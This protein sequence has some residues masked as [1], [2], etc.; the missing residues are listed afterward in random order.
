MSQDTNFGS[1]AVAESPLTIEYSLV[2]I[3]EIRHAVSEG[4]QRLSRGGLEVGGVLYGTREGSAVRIQAMREIVCEHARGPSFLLSDNDRVALTGQL[5]RGQEDH[6]LEGMVAVGWFLSHTRG[7]IALTES[8]LETFN[9]FFP[10]PWQITLVIRP[11]RTGFMRAGF[12][13]REGDGAVKAERSYL[14]FSFPDRPTPPDR[15]PRERAAPADRR[16]APP[17]YDAP[18]D[19]M[20]PAQND[21]PLFGQPAASM[22]QYLPYPETRRKWPWGLI[23]VVLVVAVVASVGLRLFAPRIAPEPIGLS[24]AERD[25]QLQIEWNHASRSITGAARGTLEITDGQD[26]RSLPLTPLDLSRGSFNYLRKSADVAIRMTVE[27]S[28]GEKTQEASRF[29]GSA[30]VAGDP[31]ELDAIRLER[32]SLQDQIATLR[33]QNKQQADRIQQLERTLVILQSRLGISQR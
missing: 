14:D 28:S 26:S 27:D 6:R 21:V 10:A 9:A 2:V 19:T 33:A 31:N 5:A 24:V 4:F 17:S 25:G 15:P 7:E 8:D 3:E 20:P 11:G 23:A 13:V 30:P 32:D 22:P 18:P 1:W 16:N 29:L 12:F